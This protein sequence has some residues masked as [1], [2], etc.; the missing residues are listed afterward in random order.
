MSDFKQSP[1]IRAIAAVATA[2]MLVGTTFPALADGPFNALAGRWVGGGKIKYEGG[3]SESISCR[4]TYFIGS[5][6]ASLQQNIRC[7]GASGNFV[8]RTEVTA[9]GNKVSGSW[10]ETVHNLSGSASGRISGDDVH[11][12]VSASNF[13]ASM[14]VV[15]S[16]RSQSVS[17][18]PQGA[19]IT[20]VSINLNKG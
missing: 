12:S 14:S 18:T 11:M 9:S 20:Q 2:G 17:I 4:V 10:T 8:V 7:A 15:T 3:K 1:L 6:G 16:G 19:A 5:G 13:T